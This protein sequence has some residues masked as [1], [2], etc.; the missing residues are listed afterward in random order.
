[1]RFGGGYDHNWV[2]NSKDGS[3]APAVTLYEKTTGRFMEVWTTEPCIQFYCGNFM[4]DKIPNKRGK[5]L[6][7]RGGLA[8]E[9]QHA[10]DSPNQPNFPSTIVHP[11]QVYR[12][13]TE[14]RFATK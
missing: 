7:H 10:P 1:L 11:G 14:Y 3:L 4:T 13:V 12:T 2:L 5:S 9:T 8:L 6:C